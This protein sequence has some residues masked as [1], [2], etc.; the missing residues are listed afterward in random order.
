MRAYNKKK[1]TNKKVVSPYKATGADKPGSPAETAARKKVQ[2]RH[3]PPV[4]G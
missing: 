4:Y 2:A 3:K 1:A